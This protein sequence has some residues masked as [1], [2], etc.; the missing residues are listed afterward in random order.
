VQ[1]RWLNVIIFLKRNKKQTP[2]SALRIGVRIGILNRE[3][4]S[5][6]APYTSR[7]SK[8]NNRFGRMHPGSRKVFFVLVISALP[9]F[10][11]F[12]KATLTAVTVPNAIADGGGTGA[13]GTPYA[14]FVKIQ[15]WTAG[16]RSQ[17]YLKVYSSTNNEYMWTGSTW[18]TT[19][20][21]ALS[22]QHVVTV[23]VSGNWSG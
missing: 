11:F 20:T 13:T 6:T 5:A 2:E 16:A 4:C 7:L 17:A 8:K 3:V 14:V 22:N 23:D 12:S 9:V 1:M 21:Y 10:Q 18:S 15:G 19:T